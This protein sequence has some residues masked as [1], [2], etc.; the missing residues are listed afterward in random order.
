MIE[1]EGAL[2]QILDNTKELT[3][4]KVSI[5][6]SAG[7]ML[8]E[9]VYSRIEMPPF[10]K[11]AMDGYAVKTT[12]IKGVPVRLRCIGS[13]EAGATFKKGLKDGE[14][15]K[16]MTGA[17]LPKDTDSVV[18]V[19]QTRTR[20]DY[21]E[22]MK[23]VKRW[24]NVCFQGEDIKR[25]QKVLDKRKVISTSDIALL[26]TIGRCFV[27]VIKKPQVAVLNTGGEIIPPGHKLGERQIYNSNGPQ[28]LALLKSDGLNPR[29]LGIVKDEPRQLKR[30]IKRGLKTDILLVSGGVSMGDCDLVPGI[31]KKLGV[32]KIFHKVN[33]KPG[34]PLFFGAHKDTLIFGIPGNP[35]SNFLAYH[36]F[37]RPALYKMA[38]HKEPG[39]KAEEGV[40]E[41][42]FYHGIGK[43]K[44]DTTSK[45]VLGYCR[46]QFSRKAGR[47][48]FIPVKIS[49]RETRYYL[50]PVESHG[51]ADI[52]ALSRADGFMVVDATVRVV[53]AKSKINFI[54][55]KKESII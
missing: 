53:K 12:D 55:W 37:I 13:I 47:K 35:V 17:A 54:T 42:T 33:I 6:D 45:I 36:I 4:E 26:A 23:S 8:M 49:K 52:L 30:T 38:G 9:D 43:Y 46:R 1:F 20:P 22:I 10:N 2:K 7:R 18:M 3:T 19:E 51:S 41:K 5:D 25:E 39:L 44:Q 16:I 31:L 15:V 24:Q 28:L 14:C 50:V 40:L 27:R 34:K 21:V 29:D 11:S 32:K 48:H